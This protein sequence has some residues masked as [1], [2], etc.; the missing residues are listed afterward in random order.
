MNP[1]RYA[2]TSI[3]KKQ[4]SLNLKSGIPKIRELAEGV[5]VLRKTKDGI[6]QYVRIN[7][8]LYKFKY[9]KA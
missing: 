1:L 7:N 6:M 9:E 8:L 3:H 5:P 2:R 4:D